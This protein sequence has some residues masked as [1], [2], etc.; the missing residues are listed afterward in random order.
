MSVDRIRMYEYGHAGLSDEE[1]RQHSIVRSNGFDADVVVIATSSVGEIKTVLTLS[2]GKPC[3]V[4]Y[5]ADLPFDHDAYE[6][7]I[8]TRRGLPA[9]LARLA[10]QPPSKA[11]GV[12]QDAPAVAPLPVQG[13]APSRPA[14]G[15]PGALLAVLGPED[16]ARLARAPHGVLTPALAHQ[17]IERHPQM[18][19]AALERCA[20]FIYAKVRDDVPDEWRK[21]LDKIH[22][23]ADDGVGMAVGS[24]SADEILRQATDNSV[25]ID[26]RAVV[27]SRVTDAEINAYA[28]RGR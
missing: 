3:V 27:S 9:L 11:P 18:A 1:L 23:A 7:R 21:R 8:G 14:A 17:M 5:G 15:T 4:I 25:R 28:R 6:W 10:R 20:T 24:Q 16:A 19:L 13:S 26:K 2:A 12:P 22:L